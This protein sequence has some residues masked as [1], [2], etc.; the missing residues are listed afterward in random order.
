VTTSVV[1][2]RERESDDIDVTAVVHI[3]IKVVVLD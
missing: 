1:D 3:M 2:K